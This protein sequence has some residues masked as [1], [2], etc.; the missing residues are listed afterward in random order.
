M[1]ATYAEVICKNIDQLAD[2]AV[3]R[4]GDQAYIN[5]YLDQ[6]FA[7][8]ERIMGRSG[9]AERPGKCDN[10]FALVAQRQE[11]KGA[12][13]RKARIAGIADFAGRTLSSRR[14]K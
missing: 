5:Q 12:S 7:F 9:L 1:S 4:P 10:A 13:R 11:T 3:R 6:L 14:S 2:A 8:S